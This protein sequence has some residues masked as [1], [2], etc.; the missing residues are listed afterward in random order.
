MNSIRK[1]HLLLGCFFAPALFFFVVSG[2]LQTFQLHKDLKNSG[3]APEILKEVARV[4][5]EQRLSS[6]VPRQPSAPF[7]WFVL[8]MSAGFLATGALGVAMAFRFFR[9]RWV[10]WALLA[11]GT[12]VPIVLLAL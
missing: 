3:R 7:R 4:H 11:A 1:M 12:A 2:A 8:L 5:M 6:P 10:V 9:P